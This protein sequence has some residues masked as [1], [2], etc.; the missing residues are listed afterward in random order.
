MLLALAI[1][2]AQPT[3]PTPALEAET[4]QEIEVIGQ[5]LAN[6]RGR[7]SPAGQAMRCITE[8]STGDP[9]IDR[10]GCDTMVVC[11]TP[12]RSRIQSAHDRSRS[13]SERRTL[14]AAYSRDLTACFTEQHDRRTADLAE[15]RYQARNGTNDARD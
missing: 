7:V 15:R 8:R 3:P 1:M 12:I 13:R 6:W 10:I 4:Q 11:I 9:E 14:E 2:Q 5:R